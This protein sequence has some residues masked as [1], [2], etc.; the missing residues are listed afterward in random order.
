MRDLCA[1][2]FAKTSVCTIAGRSY[3]FIRA[4][5]APERQLDT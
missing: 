4:E 1:A 3:A 2:G 5:K